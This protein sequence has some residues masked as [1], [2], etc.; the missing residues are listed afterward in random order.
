MDI[1]VHNVH[2]C[3]RVSIHNILEVILWN[4]NVLNLHFKTKTSQNWIMFQRGYI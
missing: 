1:Y 4:I 2:L 3:V